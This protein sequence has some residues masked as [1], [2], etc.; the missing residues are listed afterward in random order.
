MGNAGARV[1]WQSRKECYNWAT[2]AR[3]RGE[4]AATIGK[5][6]SPPVSAPPPDL[7]HEGRETA[8]ACYV[9]LLVDR[10]QLALHGE[11]ALAQAL[12][13]LAVAAALPDKPRN[14]ALPRAQA[15]Q[16][17]HGGGR[18]PVARRTRVG[19]VLESDQEHRH[20]EGRRV[21]LEEVHQIGRASCR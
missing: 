10:S 1:K 9:Q 21:E 4:A 19:G 16:Q 17:A 2:G 20:A 8:P 15:G 11:D 12:G 14:V 18:L 3:A 13:D 5:G 6:G 7:S